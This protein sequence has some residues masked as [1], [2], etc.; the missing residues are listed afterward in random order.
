MSRLLP[1]DK[2]ID[3]YFSEMEE[4]VRE[5]RDLYRACNMAYKGKETCQEHSRVEAYDLIVLVAEAFNMP[6][7]LNA[8]PKETIDRF[9][10]KRTKKR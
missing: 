6:E 9:N 7:I 3:W 10:K 8:V 5:I 1:T 4:H 2:G